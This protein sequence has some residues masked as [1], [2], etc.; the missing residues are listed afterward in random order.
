[1][2]PNATRGRCCCPE[3]A[4]KVTNALSAHRAACHRRLDQIAAERHRL[5]VLDGRWR[6]VA[7]G[8]DRDAQLFA[9][10]GVNVE[11][12]DAPSVSG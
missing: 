1:M 8:R 9:I 4:R 6:D 7:F 2:G 10:F 3:H 5:R 12:D 11:H